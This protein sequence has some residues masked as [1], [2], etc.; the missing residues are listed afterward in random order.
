MVGT[1][2]GTVSTVVSSPGA[3]STS[4]VRRSPLRAPCSGPTIRSSGRGKPRSGAT[5][6]VGAGTAD[7]STAVR[8]AVVSST[9]CV[10]SATTSTTASTQDTD[11]ISDLMPCTPTALPHI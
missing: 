4:G 2:D 3:S 11:A 6:V 9:G 7:S 5:I 1:I 8:G 10:P